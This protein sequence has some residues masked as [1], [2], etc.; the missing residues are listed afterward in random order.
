MNKRI[1]TVSA[2]ST[3]EAKKIREEFKNSEYAKDYILNILVSGN[4]DIKQNLSKF[5]SARLNR[6]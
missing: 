5:L 3:E 6:A 1:I 2:I 4:E